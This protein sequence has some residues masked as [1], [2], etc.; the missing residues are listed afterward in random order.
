M[1]RSA[2]ARKAAPAGYTPPFAVERTGPTVTT[3]RLSVA[4]T[5]WEQWFLLRSDAH[6]DNVHCRQ[7]LELRHLREAAERDAGILDFGDLFCAMQGKWDKRADAEQLRPE[8]RGKN[9]LDELVAYCADFYQPF[10]ERWVLMS[11]GNHETS[12]ERKHQTDLTERLVERLNDRTGSQIL[13]GT[14]AGWVRFQFARGTKR[15]SVRLRYTHGYGGGGPVTRDVIQSARQAVFLGNADIVCSGHTHDAW[16]LPI[17]REWLLDSGRTEVREMQFVKCGGY[18]DEFSPGNGWAVEKG[19]QPKPL[20]AYW[21]RF[22]WRD[23]AQGEG[24]VFE[25]QRAK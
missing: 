13:A 7:D 22:T 3:V 1:S 24:P 14:Y 19:I 9:Y 12:I 6:H 4:G 11:R 10:A 8:L 25:V 21:L 16:E 5:K 23:T 17:A 18:K 20:G 15:Q 2:A